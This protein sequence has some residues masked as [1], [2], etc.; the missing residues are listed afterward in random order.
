MNPESVRRLRRLASLPAF[1]LLLQTGCVSTAPV[2]ISQ[3]PVLPMD[4]A[5]AIVNQNVD[6]IDGTLR[7]SGVVDG[8]YEDDKGRRQPFSMDATL[9]FCSPTCLRLDMKK[10]FDR[11]LQVGANLEHYWLDNKLTNEFLCGKHGDRQTQRLIFQPAQLIEA[12]GLTPIPLDLARP[13]EAGRYQRATDSHQKI[14]FVGESNATGRQLQ[15]EYW[16]D[17][18]EP[19]LVGKV[20]F[21][22]PDGQEAL[23]SELSDYRR[24]SQSGPW[25]PHSIK[26]VWQEPDSEMRFKINQWKSYP[27]LNCA[28]IQFATPESCDQ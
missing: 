6:R 22:T 15:K 1:L 16:I 18:T 25:L 12:L 2:V 7:A 10:L 28:S 19:R 23:V 24:V 14:L 9:F 5:I 8:Y 27:N 13:G 20:V 26:A 21:L 3:G 11:K 4:D 17:R